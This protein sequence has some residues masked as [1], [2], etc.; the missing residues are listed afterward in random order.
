MGDWEAVP[1]VVSGAKPLVGDL[2]V[3]PQ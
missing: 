3:K 2:G 1:P